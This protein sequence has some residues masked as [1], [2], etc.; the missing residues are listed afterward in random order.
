MKMQC[1]TYESEEEFDEAIA[2]WKESVA[3]QP[4]SP[5]THTSM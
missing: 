4:A 5:D 2:V 3:L 1:K